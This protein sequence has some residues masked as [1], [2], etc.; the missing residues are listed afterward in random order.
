V[1]DDGWD[2]EMLVSLHQHILQDHIETE[3]TNIPLAQVADM[4]VN[5]SD[6]DD[7]KADCYIDDIF[8]AFLERDVAR[9]AHM[10]PFVLFLLGR[11]VQP[12]E[13]LAWDDLLSIKKFITKP[14]PS[15]WKIV[16][17]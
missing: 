7:P 10:V 4:M 1:R 14:N 12:D 8:A 3:D 13:S 11:P 9:V 15:K 6:D 17:G 5:M 2:H 16:L